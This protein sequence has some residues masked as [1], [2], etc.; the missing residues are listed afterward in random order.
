[1]PPWSKELVTLQLVHGMQ[2]HEFSFQFTLTRKMNLDQQEIY[3]FWGLFWKY[4]V[5][6]FLS[7]SRP[8]FAQKLGAFLD[9]QKTTFLTK[10]PVF[11]PLASFGPDDFKN[12]SS[13]YFQKLASNQHNFY[14]LY[15]F[16]FWASKLSQ[17]YWGKFNK[18]YIVFCSSFQCAPRLPPTPIF[19]K[20][21]PSHCNF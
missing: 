14:G 20:K 13:K 5:E 8:F 16:I 7:L 10:I 2:F 15:I 4:L 18:T 17:S 6:L 12:N 21:I 3:T 9:K 11:D 19:V 1:M